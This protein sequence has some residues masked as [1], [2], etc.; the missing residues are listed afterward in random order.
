MTLSHAPSNF[1]YGYQV[2]VA[3]NNV[4]G[5]M[6][7]GGWFYYEGLFVD[8]AGSQ[9]EVSGAGDFAFDQDCCPQY[10]LVREWCVEDCSGNMTCSSQTITFEDLDG[11]GGM[12]GVLGGEPAA[13]VEIKGDFDIVTVRPNPSKD[14]SYVEFQSNTNNSLT[15]EVYDMSGRKIATLF[16]GNVEKDVKYQTE[17][18]VSGLESGLYNIRLFSLSHQVNENLLYPNKLRYTSK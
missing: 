5:N 11:D 17:L 12:P 9:E 6:G 13:M 2:G 7:S 1:F 18:Q 3:A 4:N 14:V 16:Q 8:P 10:W 15:L